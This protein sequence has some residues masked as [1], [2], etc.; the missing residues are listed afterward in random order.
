MADK[1]LTDKNVIALGLLIGVVVF[2]YQYSREGKVSVPLIVA[3]LI[4]GVPPL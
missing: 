1:L 2:V 4:P 3:T